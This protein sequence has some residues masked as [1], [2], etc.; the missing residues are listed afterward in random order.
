MFDQ[1]Y[2]EKKTEI[3]T[4]VGKCKTLARTIKAQRIPELSFKFGTNIPSREIADKLVDGYL[5][6]SESVFRILHVPS[7][8]KEYE[9]FWSSPDSVD[10][11]FVIQLQL[12]M[13]IGSTI[14]DELFTLRQSAVQW[15]Y[16]AQCW[17][18]SPVPKTRLTLSGLQVMLL[19][20]MAQET[21][22]VGQD[23]VWIPVGQVVRTAIYMGFHR[24]PNKLPKMNRFRSEM[25]RRL[26]NTILEIALQASID[27]GGPP[28][29]FFEE[30]DTCA[31][32]DCDDA[33]LTSD[34]PSTL[35]NP[36]DK[37]TDM[38]MPLALRATFSARLA[39]A[40]ALNE[41]RGQN[42]YDDTIRLHG[43]LGTAYKSLSQNLQRFSS[44][45]R[46]PT[47]FQR[48][49]LDFL[50]RR[51]FMTLHLPY[52]GPGMIEP[53]YA[54]SKKTVVETSAKLYSLVFPLASTSPRSAND[55]R[56][57]PEDAD[58]LGRLTT[59]AAGLFRN[60]ISQA[61][62]AIAFE[63][64]NQ[65]QEDDSM[66]LP[67]PRTDLLNIF[68]DSATWVRHRI[69][70]GETNIKG[71]MFTA[72]LLGQVEALLSGLKGP[73][74]VDATVKA[75]TEA[76]RDGLELLKQHARPNLDEKTTAVDEQFSFDTIMAM[77]EDWDFDTSV[78]LFPLQCLI[79]GTNKLIQM[80]NV[81]YDFISIESVFG[82]ATDPND[83]M[84]PDLAQW[85]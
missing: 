83:A 33:Q 73:E 16:E 53:A 54:F 32:S 48:R 18:V 63:V 74:L 45:E 5:R 24:D 3:M 40:Q 9:K 28:L 25:R 55:L 11:S 12:V 64:Q 8:Q 27:S 85:Q 20:C 76:A 42:T 31:P 6:T 84:A 39:I 62:M 71:Y 44:T 26:W 82:A 69:K 70:A 61:S 36:N 41:I 1:Q 2:R 35:V 23:L 59:C 77:D 19:H 56:L 14:Y 50:V 17:L 79:S 68:R 81:L 75:G 10:P 29:I 46:K 52:F 60:I 43:Q 37:F 7:F 30:F 57:T 15:V 13:A 34:D 47:P 78:S 65:L 49:F 21:A 66:G 22:S 51:Y 72:G 38:T 58:D 4:L 67:T 80:Q